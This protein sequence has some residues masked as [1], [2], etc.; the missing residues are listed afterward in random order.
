MYTRMADSLALGCFVYVQVMPQQTPMLLKV[1]N[2][3][4]VRKNLYRLHPFTYCIKQI[5]FSYT[6]QIN[7]K[8]FE[9]K[10]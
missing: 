8:L 6:F 4:S 9:G 1:Q 2:L 5:Y 3:R 10:Y 7:L